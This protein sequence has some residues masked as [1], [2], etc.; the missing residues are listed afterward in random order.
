MPIVN[1]VI[2]YYYREDSRESS[3]ENESFFEAGESGDSKETDSGLEN[4]EGNNDDDPDR[5]VILCGKC[6]N[7]QE[8]F[9]KYL[10]F[11]K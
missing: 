10:R 9:N 7:S 8:V 1:Y 4:R 2:L 3:K 6:F 5:H 11:I